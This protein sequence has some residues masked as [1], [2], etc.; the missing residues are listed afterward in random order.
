MG[1]VEGG[2]KKMAKGAPSL[3]RPPRQ[4]AAA[5]PRAS[6]WQ[7][8]GAGEDSFEWLQ[9]AGSRFRRCGTL[10]SGRARRRGGERAD[11]ASEAVIRG[12]PSVAS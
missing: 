12:R 10:G 1:A 5:P 6:G 9:L 3:P 8:A 4:A 11:L 7:R 2:G